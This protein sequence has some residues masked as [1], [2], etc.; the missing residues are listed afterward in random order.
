VEDTDVSEEHTASIFTV[1]DG[2]RCSLSAGLMILCQ[3]F[4]L[5][6]INISMY[7]PFC[8]LT[9]TAMTTPDIRLAV[10]VHKS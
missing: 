3:D 7:H 9:Q 2:G 5:L 10:L 1:E 4:S 6:K 8:A